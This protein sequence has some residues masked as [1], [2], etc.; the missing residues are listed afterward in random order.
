MIRVKKI[1][2][3]CSQKSFVSL[4]CFKFHFTVGIFSGQQENP[5]Y[6]QRIVLFISDNCRFMYQLSFIIYILI[7]DV[8]ECAALPCKNGGT[9]AD[10]VNGYICTC[11]LGYTGL[12]CEESMQYI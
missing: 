9:C 12:Q 8:D 1:V 11:N 3:T 5:N 2:H 10:M 6:Q 7:L 4:F